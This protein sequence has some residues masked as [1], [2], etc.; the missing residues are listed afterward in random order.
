MT[1]PLLEGFT[2][3]GNYYKQGGWMP[4]SNKAYCSEC[5]HAIIDKHFLRGITPEI[6]RRYHICP[7]CLRKDK[8]LWLQL[9]YEGII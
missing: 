9:K 3:Q 1:I 5:Y 7:A 6:N 8:T 4:P 2:Y